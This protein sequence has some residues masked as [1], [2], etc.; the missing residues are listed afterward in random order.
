MPTTPHIP[1]LRLGEPYTS[2]EQK[3]VCALGT[4]EVVARLSMGNAGLVRRDAARFAEARESLASYSCEEL[5][6]LC[7]EA[8]R[9]FM[10]DALPLGDGATQTPDDYV[11]QLSSTS[12]LPHTLVRKNMAKVHEALTHV[13]DILRGL[14]RGLPPQV[15]DDGV[16]ALPAYRNGDAPLFV[17]FFPTTEALGVVM[18]SN[19]PGVNALWL[20]ALALR[21]PVILRPG[22]EEPWTP[23]RI[24]Q[25]F[26][27]A[28]LPREA[29]GFY[30]SDHEGAAAVMD[31]CGRSIIFG[32]ADTVKRYAGDPRVE[33]HGP[34][35]S[36]VVLGED[37]IDYW[38]DYLDVM[39]DS[40]AANSGRSCI[41]ASAIIVPRHAD[42]I[43]DAVAQRL[44]AIEPTALDDPDARLS[45]IANP[46]IAQWADGQ[47]TQGLKSP[48]A[49]DVTA[50]ARGQANAE[51][52]V[53]FEGRTYL[54]PTLIRCDDA[55]HPLANVEFMF[56]F[57]S[58]LEVPREA[59]LQ[60]IGQ[61]LVVTA[62][63]DDPSLIDA[64]LASPDIHRLNLGPMPTSVAQW[65]QPHEGNLFELLYQRRA[66]Q[67][68]AS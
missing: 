12:G 33:V 49:R 22:G 65:D 52:R 37:V 17:S 35:W 6:A 41:N 38:E 29:L 42:A 16:G 27:A 39:V 63:T 18:P 56:P 60:T 24:I 54:R 1:I 62:I 25:S 26:Y 68:A 4:G 3:D 48:G 43:A 23:W 57:A 11:R 66:I 67:R 9:I 45:A 44:A 21:T 59:L 30:P 13:A 2:V 64:L 19:S 40:I 53:T 5:I 51:R 55:S 20:P 28:G 7:A 15:L 46:A 10:Q 32:G 58:V 61:A 47:I 36:K 31:A 50:A 34:G 14:T 8:G